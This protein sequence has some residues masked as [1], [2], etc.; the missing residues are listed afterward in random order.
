MTPG[1]VAIPSEY[2][3]AGDFL[4]IRDRA[5]GQLDALLLAGNCKIAR[6]K[7]E[8]LVGHDLSLEDHL[9]AGDLL[10]L[11]LHYGRRR[12]SILGSIYL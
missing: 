2:V 10:S 8:P 11:G 1:S 4:R 3:I 12:L 6:R 7:I 5:P 9:H